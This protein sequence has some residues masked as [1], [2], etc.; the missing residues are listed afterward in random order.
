MTSKTH[1]DVKKIIMMSKRPSWC[2]K[3]PW[4]QTK[5]VRHDVKNRH[6]AEKIVMTSKSFVITSKTHYGIKKYVMTSKISSWRKKVCVGIRCVLWH[7]KLCQVLLRIF[8]QFDISTM[9]RF[10]VINDYVF[11]TILM[12]LYFDL[13]PW[14]LTIMQVSHPATSISSFVT[15]GLHLTN[16]LRVST[17]NINLLRLIIFVPLMTSHTSV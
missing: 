5:F 7:Q 1:H 11:F 4:R 17:T 9:C 2:K 3:Y 14:Y 16:A 10:R 8:W 15:I 12:T 6:N 13:F